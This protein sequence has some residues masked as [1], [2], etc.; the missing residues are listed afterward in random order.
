MIDFFQLEKFPI[1][2]YELLKIYKSNKIRKPIKSLINSLYYLH[3]I[4]TDSVDLKIE[5]RNTRT[6][7]SAANGRLNAEELINELLLKEA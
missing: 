2:L 4:K 1:H 3:K 7:S 6:L 5:K